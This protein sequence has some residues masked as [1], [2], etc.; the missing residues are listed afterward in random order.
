MLILKKFK[1]TNFR[2][3]MDSGWIDCD[4]VTT[5]VGINEAGK[6]NAI[7]AL[8]KLKPARNEGEAEINLRRDMPNSKYSEWR[9]QPNNHYFIHAHFEMN[10]KTSQI[11]TQTGCSADDIAGGL[12]VK[13]TFEGKYNI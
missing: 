10:E 7:L 11:L 3:I 4:N 2:S 12:I 8:W 1:V 6:S 5:L 13:R 9:H